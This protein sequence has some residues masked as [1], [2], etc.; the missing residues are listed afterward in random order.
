MKSLNQ[1]VLVGFMSLVL[2]ALTL[3]H[4]STDEQSDEIIRMSGLT[5]LSLQARNLAQQLINEQQLTVG[6]QYEVVN[7][8]AAQWA[9][10]KVEQTLQQ[11]LQNFNAEQREQ[12]WTV[13]SSQALRSAHYKEQQ[14]IEAQHSERYQSYLQR[15]RQQS[16]MEGRMQLIQRLDQSM[17]FSS[18][19]VQTRLDVYQRLEK[20]VPNWKAPEQWQQK[21]KDDCIEFLLYAHRTTPNEQLEELIELYQTAALKNWF[22]QIQRHLRS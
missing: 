16:L 2:P 20:A 9:P 7:A 14:A 17:R 6:K 22:T 13:L 18:L 8:V 10:A 19:L 4:A 21:T 11:L 3:V 5:G 1:L 12:L 15:L